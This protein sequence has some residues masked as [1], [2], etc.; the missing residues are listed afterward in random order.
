MNEFKT[1]EQAYAEVLGKLSGGYYETDQL[2]VIFDCGYSSASLLYNELIKD[3]I[4]AMG[5]SRED[6]IQL[7]LDVK[8]KLGKI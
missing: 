2:K 4:S 1:K 5:K 3:L 6:Q 8:S 7:L